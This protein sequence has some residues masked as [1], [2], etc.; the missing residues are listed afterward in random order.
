MHRSASLRSSELLHPKKQSTAAPPAPSQSIAN[1]SHH[2]ARSR[3]SRFCSHGL[4]SLDSF[5]ERRDDGIG[6]FALRG[7]AAFDALVCVGG[8][9]YDG[10]DHSD[11]DGRDAGERKGARMFSAGL[12]CERGSTPPSPC[13]AAAYWPPESAAAA[14][15]M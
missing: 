11:D 2:D 7:N 8:Y 15:V 6:G 10:G 1:V 14:L 12:D 9:G 4:S 3:Q 5:C 13:G